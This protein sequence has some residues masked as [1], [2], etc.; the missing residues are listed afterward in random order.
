M[1]DISLLNHATLIKIL[2]IAISGTLICPDVR[3]IQSPGINF[4][5]ERIH[6]PTL[7]PF[8][9]RIPSQALL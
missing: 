2:L 9:Q 4:T 6:I 3:I 1:I 5:G 8:F 7:R